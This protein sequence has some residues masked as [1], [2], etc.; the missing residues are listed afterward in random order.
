MANGVYAAV[1]SVQR[2]PPDPALN[3]PATQPDRHELIARHDPMLPPRELGNSLIAGV[4][5]A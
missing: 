5:L 3:L 1:N 4:L 2:L